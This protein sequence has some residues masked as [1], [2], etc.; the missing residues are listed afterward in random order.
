MLNLAKRVAIYSPSYLSLTCLFWGGK[1]GLVH[2]PLER[3]KKL[4]PTKTIIYTE[5]G[6]K[7]KLFLG[8]GG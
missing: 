2:E 7:K 3:K 5:N 4:R 1:E 6:E 8:G